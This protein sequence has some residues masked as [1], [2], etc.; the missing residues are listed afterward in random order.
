MQIHVA[1]VA[2]TY[3]WICQSDLCIEIGTWGN[4]SD[5]VELVYRPPLTIKIDLTAIVMDN[6]ASL[7][8]LSNKYHTDVR[9]SLTSCTPSSKT[10]KVEGYVIFA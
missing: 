9:Q 3:C 7:R 1:N 5:R 8:Q 10:P 2:A 4:V 6:L